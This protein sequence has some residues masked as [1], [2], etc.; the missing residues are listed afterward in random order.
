MEFLVWFLNK[1]HMDLGGTRKSGS[2]IIQR[3]FQ[4]KKGKGREREGKGEEPQRE[5]AKPKDFL[6]FLSS[7][8]QLLLLLGFMNMVVF[9]KNVVPRERNG[10]KVNEVS[11]EEGEKTSPFLYLPLDVPASPLFKN[12]SEKNII[13]QVFFC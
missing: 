8:S 12:E 3:V 6:T 1:L 13:P 7:L 2:S 4:G 11:W 10:K 9:K 5:R